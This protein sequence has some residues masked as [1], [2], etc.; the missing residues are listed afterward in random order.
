MIEKEVK[1]KQK[2]ETPGKKGELYGMY[3]SIIKYFRLDRAT[4]NILNNK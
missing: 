2:R 4:F 3:L 1:M